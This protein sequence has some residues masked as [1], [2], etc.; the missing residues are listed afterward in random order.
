MTLSDIHIESALDTWQQE[1]GT[2]GAH[3]ETSGEFR[4]GELVTRSPTGL[5]VIWD[6]LSG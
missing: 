6:F 1:L 3:E 2:G 4:G 5:Y